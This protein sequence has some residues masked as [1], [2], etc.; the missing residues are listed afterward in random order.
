MNSHETQQSTR[1]Y[2]AGIYVLCNCT[3]VHF[4][5]CT[6]RIKVYIFFLHPPHQKN[7]SRSH[8]KTK[9]TPETQKEDVLAS[10]TGRKL[11]IYTLLIPLLPI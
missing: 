7:P 11:Y 10:K 2:M 5:L 6:G 1:K 8:M 3:L 4:P 9:K